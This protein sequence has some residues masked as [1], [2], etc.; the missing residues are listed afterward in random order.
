MHR[1]RRA[2]FSRRWTLRTERS[3]SSIGS[4]PAT[5]SQTPL[6]PIT[7]GTIV[8]DPGRSGKSSTIVPDSV[9]AKEPQAQVAQEHS[10]TSKGTLLNDENSNVS[11]LAR[12]ESS[13]DP[14][15]SPSAAHIDGSASVSFVPPTVQQTSEKVA[16][17]ALPEAPVQAPLSAEPNVTTFDSGGSGVPGSVPGSVLSGPPN[18][19]GSHEPHP[20]PTNRG[21]AFATPRFA[22]KKKS[23]SIGVPPF[24]T[25]ET[26]QT[27]ADTSTVAS[28]TLQAPN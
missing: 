19:V 8:T 12:S 2:D 18:I 14:L 16:H 4:F 10:E 5:T 20:A 22:K 25:T 24:S 1:V 21:A 17:T 28:E 15:M 3:H 13:I 7:N 27:C 9:A 26:L 23:D 6:Q 11:V